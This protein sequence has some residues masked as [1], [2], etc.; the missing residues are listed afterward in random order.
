MATFSTSTTSSATVTAT[1]EEVWAALTDPD[2][3]ARLTPF[4]HRVTER[5]EHWVWE[6]TKVPVLGR[7]FSFRFTERMH[8]EQ[9]RRIRFSHDPD[10]GD[11]AES[12]GVDGWYLLEPRS[13]GTRL[14]TQMAI[15][16]D[17]PFPG[18]TR[19]AVTTAMKGVVTFMGQ[20]FSQQ[21]LAH[22]GART[23]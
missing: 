8:F 11:G 21:L 13:A 5:G 12:A 20:R 17:L 6:M 9:P 22:L 10:A 15:T 23:T 1:P 14:E 19:P 7:S 4:L 2:V 16:V 18:I 3:V